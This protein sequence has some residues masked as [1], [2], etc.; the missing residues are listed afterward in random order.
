MTHR[1]G[2]GRKGKLIS[3]AINSGWN[4]YFGDEDLFL[5]VRLEGVLHLMHNAIKL[6]DSVLALVLGQSDTKI[7]KLGHHIFGV[8][9]N[10]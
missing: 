5:V 8:G 1:F 9:M 6:L 7:S 2:F 4:S 10:T 3:Y